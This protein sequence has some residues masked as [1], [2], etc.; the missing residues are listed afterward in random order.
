MLKTSNK[1]TPKILRTINNK[2]NKKKYENQFPHQLD[3][4]VFLL[5]QW[6]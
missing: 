5:N 2:T 3:I 4:K 1:Y 6:K